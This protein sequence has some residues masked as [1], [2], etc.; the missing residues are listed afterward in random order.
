MSELLR[1]FS[2][3]ELRQLDQGRR[4]RVDQ[5]IAGLD[6]LTPVQG[7]IQAVHHGT[8]LEVTA[9]AETIITLCCDRCL[10]HFNHPLRAEV[11]ELVELRGQGEGGLASIDDVSLELAREGMPEGADLDD[12]LD[13]SG[14]FDPERWL[15]EQ[16]S[17]Q[18]PLVN[19][20]GDDCPGPATWSSEPTGGD[21]RWAALAQ[22][23]LGAQASAGPGQALSQRSAERASVPPDGDSQTP[24]GIPSH[25]TASP[26]D[27]EA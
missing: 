5:R 17:L 12:R 21:P 11:H 4:W 26:N 22:L 18:L 7:S 27:L 24:P 6:S 1:P 23:G 9:A 10:Q 2:L 19:R 16:L 25:A 15:F 8:A 20:C 13:P 3:A 14:S